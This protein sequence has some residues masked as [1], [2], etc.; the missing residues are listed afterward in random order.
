MSSLSAGFT[1]WFRI[2]SL[3]S[4]IRPFFFLTFDVGYA[5]YYYRDYL[6]YQV[7]R[8]ED[9][10]SRYEDIHY[11]VPPPQSYGGYFHEEYHPATWP[12][13]Y[14]AQQRNLAFQ[15]QRFL[16]AQR[17][18][19]QWMLNQQEAENKRQKRN[20]FKNFEQ[21]PQRFEPV[22]GRQRNNRKP[23]IRK[24]DKKVDRL[25][26][27]EKYSQES[28]ERM[29]DEE[30]EAALKEKLTTVEE[31]RLIVEQSIRQQK[32]LKKQREGSSQKKSRR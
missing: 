24:A 5:Q 14:R 6:E 27:G 26:E 21:K 20:E 12:Y 9:A 15:R 23:K 1:I 18:Q 28:V 13:I 7:S 4:E 10:V 3:R 16:E 8:F 11:A 29:T 19:N 22:I 31:S 2:H 25:A 30:I 32:Q 17:F